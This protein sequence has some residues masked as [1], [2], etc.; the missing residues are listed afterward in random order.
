MAV[1]SKAYHED[2]TNGEKQQFAAPRTSLSH[3]VSGR[4]SIT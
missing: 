1:L 2:E 3:T 4:L